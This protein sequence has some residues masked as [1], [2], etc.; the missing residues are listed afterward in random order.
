MIRNVVLVRLPEG[1]DEATR[2]RLDAALA[3]IA[4]LDLPGQVA[5]HTGLD[6]GLREGGWTAAIVNDWVDEDAYRGYD[7]DPEHN[8]HRAVLAEVSEQLARVQYAID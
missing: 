6:V 5:N 4:A 1:A 7:A 8:H 3:G 2:A